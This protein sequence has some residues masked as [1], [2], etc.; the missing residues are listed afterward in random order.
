MKKFLMLLAVISVSGVMMAQELV[1]FSLS[2]NVETV[3]YS[4]VDAKGKLLSSSKDSIVL[5]SGDFINGKATTYSF[6]TENGKTTK[7]K[8]PVI[9]K[10]G[11]TIIDMKTVLKEAMSQMSDEEDGDIMS[12]FGD[13]DVKGEPKGIPVDI[14]VGDVLPEFEMVVDM[15]PIDTKIKVYDR[16]VVAE[17]TITTEAGTFDCF[18]IDNTQSVR[19]LFTSNKEYSRTWYS[20]G[21]GIV[22]QDKLDKK[23]KVLETKTL[24]SVVFR[25]VQPETQ[26]QVEVQAEV[27]AEN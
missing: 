16:K 26:T 25:E 11:E 2:E 22:R 10:D 1:P 7:V 27:E 24:T 6:V 19:A 4:T 21:Y 8:V 17:E 23:G 13:V 18:V 9:Y 15:G 20:R 12:L 3:T 5:E 14:K